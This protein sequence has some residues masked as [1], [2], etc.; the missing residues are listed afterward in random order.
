MGNWFF[1][2]E[3]DQVWSEEMY[4]KTNYIFQSQITSIIEFSDRH[5]KKKKNSK[6]NSI[7]LFFK[8]FL[9]LL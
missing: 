8:I 5:E 4:F 2:S 9:K 3:Y 6:Y 1:I 7:D